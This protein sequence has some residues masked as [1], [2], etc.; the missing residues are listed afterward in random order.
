MT[1]QSKILFGVFCLALLQ[2]C[3]TLGL[4]RSTGTPIGEQLL[5]LTMMKPEEFKADQALVHLDALFDHLDIPEETRRFYLQQKRVTLFIDNLEAPSLSNALVIARSNVDI[6]HANNVIV[7]AAGQVNISHGANL[8]L[9]AGKAIHVSH[10]NQKTNAASQNGIFVTKESLTLVHDRNPVIYAVQG[11][12]LSFVTESQI[13]NTDVD[14][15]HNTPYTE[16]RIKPLFHDEPRRKPV[17]RKQSKSTAKLSNETIPTTGKRCTYPPI[18]ESS[19]F[20]KML[21]E[22][23][24]EADCALIESAKIQCEKEPGID[25]HTAK[26]A[27]EKWTFHGCGREVDVFVSGSVSV[28]NAHA[29][30]TP[31]SHG[32]LSSPGSAYRSIYIVRPMTALT[33]SGTN[34]NLRV[35]D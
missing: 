19:L 14:I 31:A 26:T 12:T 4:E 27:Q 9:V 3:Q 22:I 33:I 29:N 13:Y 23:R 10:H 11:A 5:E 7:I 32:G 1:R 30:D 20:K 34:T 17:S 2:A 15:P 16:K 21:P 25:G 24:R 28:N 18:D 8:V 35:E 6:A